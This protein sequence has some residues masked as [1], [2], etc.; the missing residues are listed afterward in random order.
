[1]SALGGASPRGGIARH[2]T[3]LARALAAREGVTLDLWSFRRLY[4]R[5]LYPGESDRD[6]DAAPPEALAPRFAL[7]AVNP[8]GWRGAAR[9]IA[10]GAPD[11]AVLPAWTFFVAPCLGTLALWTTMATGTPRALS[12]RASVPRQG[13]TKKVQAGRTA[14]SGAPA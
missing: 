7:D 6:P 8:L 10:A 5:R 3:A 4:P 12:P 9:R 14:R 2:T 13:A 11:L 1:M